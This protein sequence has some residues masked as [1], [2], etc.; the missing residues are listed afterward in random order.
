M[1][2]V[3]VTYKVKSSFVT[4]NQTNI[5]AFIDDLYR[6]NHPELRYVVYLG[7]DG[8]TF[9]HL[10][11]YASNQAQQVLLQ[12][13]SF[14]SFQQQRDASGLE[15]DPWIEQMHPVASSYPLFNLNN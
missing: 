5:Q 6:I 2:T 1:K 15:S 8:Q 3:K 13:P 10:A 11:T 9:T 7:E 12:L 14:L 4:Q